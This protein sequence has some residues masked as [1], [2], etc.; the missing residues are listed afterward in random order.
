MN[1]H[2]QIQEGLLYMAMSPDDSVFYIQVTDPDWF[3]LDPVS[4]NCVSL[5]W[6]KPGRRKL[7][8]KPGLDTFKPG[9]LNQEHA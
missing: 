7:L 6:F 5:A 9:T 1:V 4:A 3:E 8:F 2:V